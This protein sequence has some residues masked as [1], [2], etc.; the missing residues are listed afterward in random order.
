MW[1]PNELC[2]G[3]TLLWKGLDGYG[4]VADYSYTHP[5]SLITS[6][7]VFNSNSKACRALCE[8]SSLSSTWCRMCF[9]PT[10]SSSCSC[11]ICVVRTSLSRATADFRSTCCRKVTRNC[12]VKTTKVRHI[13]SPTCHLSLQRVLGCLGGDDT[14]YLDHGHI[15]C[16]EDSEAFLLR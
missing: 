3:K 16:H 11:T 14:A 8:A 1:S 5:Q 9:L 12:H 15:P 2:I 6:K 13:V 4:I 7:L 10:S